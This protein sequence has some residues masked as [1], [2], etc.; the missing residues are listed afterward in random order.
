[1]RR[2]GTPVAQCTVKRLMKKAGLKSVVRSK[3]PRTTRPKVE[4]DRP[5]DLV[6]RR[7]VADAPNQP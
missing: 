7:F 1:M 5:A 3:S 2:Q 4:T 6:E